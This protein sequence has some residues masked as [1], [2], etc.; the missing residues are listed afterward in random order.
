M[1][2]FL[3]A[4]PV[5]EASE[6]YYDSSDFFT[7]N[8]NGV[9]PVC[10]TFSETEN[11]NTTINADSII[12]ITA[13]PAKLFDEVFLNSSETSDEFKCDILNFSDNTNFAYKNANANTT[14]NDDFKTAR[15]NTTAHANTS[16]NLIFVQSGAFEPDTKY[17]FKA[18]TKMSVITSQNPGWGTVT[19]ETFFALY[20]RHIKISHDRLTLMNKKS[21]L[22][23]LGHEIIEGLTSGTLEYKTKLQGLSG[24]V[25]MTYVNYSDGNTNATG[26]NGTHANSS[27]G[28]QK[29]PDKPSTL[30][31]WIFDGTMITKA[32]MAENG[33]MDGILK[34]S[35][36]YEGSIYFDKVI[37]KKARAGGGTYSVVQ[38]GRDRH[39]LSWELVPV[40]K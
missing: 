1:S 18:Y 12:K 38:K 13:I 37:I 20:N 14:T 25:T 6:N 33:T 19:D 8:Q 26:S 21:N 39:E 23:K 28:L 11:T 34:I 2:F 35:G 24:L 7:A 5:L 16:H 22:E 40:Y 15:S 4:E 30:S 3:M 32:N 9:Y 27:D 31:D 10:L 17:Y 36:M 29:T